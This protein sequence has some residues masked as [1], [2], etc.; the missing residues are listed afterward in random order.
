MAA[1]FEERNAKKKL[2]ATPLGMT[3]LFN[4]A[5]V[6]AVMRDTW[7]LSALTFLRAAVTISNCPG[8]RTPAV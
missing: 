7:L 1:R 6:W 8:W 5:A 4:D 2:A 3:P